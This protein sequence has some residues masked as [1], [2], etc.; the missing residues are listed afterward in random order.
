VFDLCQPTTRGNRCARGVRAVSGFEL[1]HARPFAASRAEIRVASGC[2]GCGNFSGNCVEYAFVD[3]RLW[4]EPRWNF[5]LGGLVLWALALV[6]WGGRGLKPFVDESPTRGALLKATLFGAIA[7]AWLFG[8]QGALWWSFWP[9]AGLFFDAL[10]P[11]MNRLLSSTN[12]E[13][14]PRTSNERL[15]SQLE[16]LLAADALKRVERR[17]L[18]RDGSRRENSAEHSW[19]LA[20]GVLVFG[21]YAREQNLDLLARFKCRSFTIWS[22]SARAI[23]SFTI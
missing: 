19:H 16:F 18:L 23:L 7:A 22:K 4:S 21:E 15:M 8:P 1:E 17:S 10:K 14:I 12:S 13:A 20:L 9:L 3:E 11:L 5:A 2:H 6:T